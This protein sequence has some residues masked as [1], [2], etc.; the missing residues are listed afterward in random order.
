MNMS[1]ND[2][3]MIWFKFKKIFIDLGVIFE[4]EIARRM[5]GG[6]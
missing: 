1:L 2:E 4:G 5:R 3:N 6:K